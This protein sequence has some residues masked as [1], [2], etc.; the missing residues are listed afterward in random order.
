[1]QCRVFWSSSGVCRR[2]PLQKLQRWLSKVIQTFYYFCSSKLLNYFKT[3]TEINIAVMMEKHIRTIVIWS[4]Q[5]CTLIVKENAPARVAKIIAQSI[6]LNI[7]LLG[8]TTSIIY[9]IKFFKNRDRNQY[10]GTDGKTYLNY[11]HMK[12]T[13]VHPQ[14]EG[15]CPCNSCKNICPRLLKHLIIY[16]VQNY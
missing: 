11:C 14:C 12:C 15:E 10:C 13:G 2:M 4:V 5:G 8:E 3:G 1:M 7:S 9:D 6:R 16:T